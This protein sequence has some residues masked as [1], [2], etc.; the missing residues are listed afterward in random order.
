MANRS[1][2]I[3]APAELMQ[4]TILAYAAEAG[5]DVAAATQEELEA[6]AI[7]TLRA[8]MRNKTLGY[9]DNQ[10]RLAAKDGFVTQRAAELEA[11]TAAADSVV[12]VFV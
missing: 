4:P 5:V 3:T 8:D 10:R 6:G 11:L 2:S 9:N 7:L 1:L 12:V